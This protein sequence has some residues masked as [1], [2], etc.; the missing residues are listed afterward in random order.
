MKIVSRN[1]TGG[2]TLIDPHLVGAVMMDNAS[3]TAYTG[4]A[5]SLQTVDGRCYQ[6]VSKGSNT[7]DGLVY[8]THSDSTCLW[9]YVPKTWLSASDF[10]TI[11]VALSAAALLGRTLYVAG[12]WTPAGPLTLDISKVQIV[13]DNAVLTWSSSTLSGTQVAIT[14]TNTASGSPYRQSI[15]KVM[16]GLELVGPSGAGTTDCLYLNRSIE[17]GISHLLFERL[18]V[19]Y[20]GRGVVFG[21]NTYLVKFRDCDFWGIASITRCKA[22]PIAGSVTPLKT[23]TFTMEEVALSTTRTVTPT[24]AIARTILRRTIFG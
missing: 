2:Q 16:S 13:G 12:S 20:F 7:A 17:P 10:S 11:E 3:L 4:P 9:R 24:K 21:N 15:L 19:H 6:K 23:A 8:L 18:N 22:A 14:I 1:S 5:T